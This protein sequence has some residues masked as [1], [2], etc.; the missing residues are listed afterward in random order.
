MIFGPPAVRAFPVIL[1]ALSDELLS[2][3]LRR[4]AGFYG[5]GEGRIL[6]HCLLDVPTF[7]HLD[8]GLAVRDQHRLGDVLRCGA[9][10][11]RR[12][13][14]SRNGKLPMGPVATVRPMQVCKQC[15]GRH[16]A[17]AVTRGARLRSWME[18][19]RISC[20]VCGARLHDARPTDLAT[21][22]DA[23]EPLLIRTAAQA[24]NGELLIDNGVRHSGRAGTPLIE[25]MRVLLLPRSIYSERRRSRTALPRLLDVV[26]SG[27]DQHLREHHSHFRPPGTLLLP[28]SVRIPV[29]AGVSMVATR[30]DYWAERLIGSAVVDIRDRLIS[31]LRSLFAAKR[32]TH[33]R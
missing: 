21:N 19:W 9:L 26:V 2:S 1:P 3:W 20:P 14:Q 23:T 27:F 22:V 32:S 4:H 5:V 31:C 7:R 29:L 24:R 30:P 25:L 8:L 6:R 10:A 18:G 11:I 13:T 15:V 33:L 12:M 17:A 16:G 28:I